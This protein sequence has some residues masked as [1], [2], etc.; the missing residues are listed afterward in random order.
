MIIASIFNPLTHYNTAPIV[1]VRGTSE[2]MPLVKVAPDY[3]CLESTFFIE[4]SKVGVTN[5]V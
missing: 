3:K 4:V 1:L 2:V 5:G